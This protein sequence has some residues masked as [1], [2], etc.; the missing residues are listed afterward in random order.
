MTRL[1]K[2]FRF[3]TP[4]WPQMAAASLALAFVSLVALALPWALR[5]LIDSVFVSHD[6]EALN[7]LALALVL[8]FV[9]QAGLSYVVTYLMSLTAQRVIADLRLAL[10]KHLMFLPLRFFDEQR[11]GELVSRLTNDVTVIQSVLTE[12]PV[13]LLR[14]VITLTGGLTLMFLLNWRLTLLTLLIVPPITA[15]AIFFGRRLQR[16]STTVQD[17]LAEATSALEEAL[18]GIR[19]VKSFTQETFEHSRYGQ[20]IEETLQTVMQ[21]IRLRATFVP[22]IN[23]LGLSSIILILWVGGR[24]VINGANTPG[25]LV[26]FIFYAFIVA[27]PLGDFASLYSQVREAN[28]ASQRL[29]E[30]LETP[31]EPISLPGAIHLARLQGQ[32]NFRAVGFAYSNGA[33]VLEAID[34]E[35]PP[36]QVIALVGSSGVGKTTLVNLIPRFFDPTSGIVEVDGQDI[37]QIDMKELRQQIGL[38]PQETFLFAGS[39]MENIRYGRPDAN[40]TDIV[41]AARAAYANEFIER[42]PDGYNCQ[43]GERGVKLSAGQRQRIAIARAILKDPRIL[44]LDEATSALDSEAERWVQAAL[45]LLMKGRTTFVIAHR[46][47]TIQ[48][49]DRILVLQ[50]GCIVEDGSHAS[51]LALDGIY[52]RLWKLQFNDHSIQVNSPL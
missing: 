24:Q 26:A 6:M 42:L 14:Q 41:S 46:L 50:D 34:F 52:T 18:S 29:F 1:N 30:I 17:R 32:V 33:V 3:V 20:R 22:L 45:E 9:I 15:L 2:L 28:G 16:L 7:K 23:L 35:A 12:A 11:V 48:R 51:L 40:E 8:L 38:V 37:S 47:S 44:I 49:A 36:A 43:V 4:Y 19:V 13:N 39:V 27:G 25:D 10:Q 21:R 5:L 31:Q